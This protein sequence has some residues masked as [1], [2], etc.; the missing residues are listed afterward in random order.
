MILSKKQLLVG[1]VLLLASL[2]FALSQ[3]YFIGYIQGADEGLAAGLANNH[4]KCE[5]PKR[6][7]F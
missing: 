2:S 1:F 3:G 6:I 4:N 7:N 5:L